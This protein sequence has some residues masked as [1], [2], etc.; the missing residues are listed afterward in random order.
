MTSITDITNQ[1]LEYKKARIERKEK[2]DMKGGR[3]KKQGAMRNALKAAQV[4]ASVFR[5]LTSF[6]RN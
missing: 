6:G 5:P 1:I 2:V 4:A 3:A